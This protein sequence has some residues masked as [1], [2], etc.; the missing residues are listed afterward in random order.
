MIEAQR[1]RELVEE[2]SDLTGY[3]VRMTDDRGI[4]FAWVDWKGR[5]IVGHGRTR[6][7]SLKSLRE[8]VLRRINATH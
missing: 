5:F 8:Q 1:I 4:K 6:L 3:T 7:E 2:I